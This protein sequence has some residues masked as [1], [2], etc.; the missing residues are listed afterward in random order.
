MT[1][2]HFLDDSDLPPRQVDGLNALPRTLE[3][4]ELN[5]RC[6]A[7]FFS[8]KSHNRF[9]SENTYNTVSSISKW[10]P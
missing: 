5:L 10:P 4:F 9:F 3:P 7:R 8:F 6:F 2:R 1:L